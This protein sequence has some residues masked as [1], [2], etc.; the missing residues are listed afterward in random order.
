[1]DVAVQ[2]DLKINEMTIYDKY[3]E[4]QNLKFIPGSYAAAFTIHTSDK[5]FVD[6]LNKTLNGFS[7]TS[8]ATIENNNIQHIA[9]A[10]M[11]V[12]EFI[13]R[14]RGYIGFSII[15]LILING[16]IIGYR[17]Y[18]QE[19]RDKEKAY[20]DSIANV[21]SMEK[22]RIDVEPI[23]NSKQKLEYYII[24]VDIEQF[25]IINDLFGYE[26]GDK[27]IAFLG[28]ILK[29]QLD[30]ESYVTRSNAECF[31]V[32]KKA[33][34]FSEIKAYLKAVFKEVAAGIYR[35]DSEYKLI[36]KAGIYEIVEDD[37]VLSSII[38][39]AN[40]AKMNMAIGHKSAYAIYSESMRQN[41]LDEKK[42]EN[43]MEKALE[44]GQF[45][46]YLQPQVDFKTR[47][48]VSA[49]ALV[50]WIDSENGVIPPI[51]FIPL[52]EKNGFICK[53]DY[54]VWEESIKTLVKW[55]ENNQIMVPLI[56][57]ISICHQWF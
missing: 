52:F 55:R 3:K 40:I 11:T 18:E 41:A 49:E 32:L 46:V 7:D 5:V 54:F 12:L 42:M 1:M 57:L 13:N 44:N 30:Q 6:I 56:F 22:F 47:K 4:L 34:E 33:K 29:E 36:L 19:K 27:V 48:I 16:A 24:S 15:L 20:K 25:K 17:K 50:R 26:E 21:S 53:L 37:F 14:Y 51:K 38:D 8:M 2:S 35:I 45:K 31:V 28:R 10:E 43:D 39:K 23:L 9:M